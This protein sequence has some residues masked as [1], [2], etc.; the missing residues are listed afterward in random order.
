MVS[1]KLLFYEFWSHTVSKFD[2]QFF[3]ATQLTC[4]GTIGEIFSRS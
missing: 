1:Q 2:T 4:K 3:V